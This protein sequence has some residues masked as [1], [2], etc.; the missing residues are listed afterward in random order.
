MSNEYFDLRVALSQCSDSAGPNATRKHPAHIPDREEDRTATRKHPAH[1]PDREED[2]TATR[3]HTAHNTDRQGSVRRWARHGSTKYIWN[4]E[5][6]N[7]ALRYVSDSQ[8]AQMAYYQ[9][10]PVDPRTIPFRPLAYFITFNTYG[11]W[12]HG[13]QRGS[14][15]YAHNVPGFPRMT[16]CPELHKYREERLKYPTYTIDERG[17]IIVLRAVIEV[18]EYRLWFLHSAHVRSNHVHVIVSAGAKPEKVMNDF[19]A[20]A[21]RALNRSNIT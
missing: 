11:S 6:L 20:Y 7:A 4:Q 13:D 1:I 3:E 18:C 5:Q 9:S 12:I 19:K 8:G 17:R 15:D 14:V 16:Y 10:P 21:S 2:R